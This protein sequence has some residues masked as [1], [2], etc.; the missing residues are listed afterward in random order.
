[1]SSDDPFDDE[2]DR[3]TFVRPRPGGR[4]SAVEP[5]IAATTEAPADRGS[6][7]RMASTLTIDVPGMGPLLAAAAP[8]LALAVKLRHTLTQADP[9]RLLAHVAQEVRRFEERVTKSGVRREEAMIARYCLC[10][11]VDESALSTPWGASSAWSRQSLLSAF[12]GETWGGEKFFSVLERMLREPAGHVDLIELL[13][14]ILLLG[15]QGQYRIAERGQAKLTDIQSQAVRVLRAQKGEVERELSPHWRGATD[16]GV[17]LAR[18]LPVW[19]CAAAAGVLLLVAYLG[20]SF[21]L[22]GYTDPVDTQV[23]AV[24]REIAVPARAVAAE[25]WVPPPAKTLD[26]AGFLAPEIAAG[27]VKVHDEPGKTT[28]TLPGAGLF[29]SGSATLNSRSQPLLKRIADAL[30]TVRG[31][32]IVTGHTDSDPIPAG[33]RLRFASNFELSQQRS[34]SV[35]KVLTSTID[36]P[37]RIKSDGRADTEPVAPNTSAENKALNRRVEILLLAQGDGA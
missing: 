26:L 37:A 20:F 36:T 15:F 32:V 23:R 14:V 10:T 24:G 13:A 7:A 17:P 25:R 11:F 33:L 34:E 2:G 35:A 16:I 6:D 1:M 9:G 27:L 4:G 21:S 29:A 5:P 31:N 22:S 8:L 28:I 30:N 12:H 19:V 3:T 18:Y